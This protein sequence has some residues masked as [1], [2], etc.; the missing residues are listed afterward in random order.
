MLLQRETR[1]LRQGERALEIGRPQAVV[2]CREQCRLRV[3]EFQD[4]DHSDVKSNT[5]RYFLL[6]AFMAG[7][8][9]IRATVPLYFT[10][11][12][13]YYACNNTE[14]TGLL[15]KEDCIN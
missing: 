7:C 15:N 8:L 4:H 3:T 5:N 10:L 11:G 2:M 6:Y 14:S 9:G 12:I 1:I 13:K